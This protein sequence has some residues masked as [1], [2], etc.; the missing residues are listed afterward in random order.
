MMKRMMRVTIGLVL[1]GVITCQ[2][3][4]HATGL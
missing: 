4:W 3:L 2:A 1:G